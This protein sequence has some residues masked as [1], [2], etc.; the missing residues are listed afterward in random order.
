MALPTS[1]DTKVTK[2]DFFNH[3]IEI[4]KIFSGISG[5]AE[6][7]V[8]TVT[9][10][11]A[12]PANYPFPVCYWRGPIEPVNAL[13]GDVFDLVAATT[14]AFYE[15][16]FSTGTGGFTAQANASSIVRDTSRSADGALRWSATAAGNTIIQAPMK[17]GVAPSTS[18]LIT[19]K[20]S[21]NSG[22]ALL[23]SISV[24]EHSSTGAYIRTVHQSPAPSIAVGSGFTTLSFTHTTSA[25]GFNTT[26]GPIDR[27]QVRVEVHAQA[28]GGYS[29]LDSVRVN[30]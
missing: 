9:G 17:T 8:I 5:C 27:F 26:T 23:G 29:Y 28:A 2:Q 4:N 19:V 25:S 30:S 14:P 10:D 18:Y 3:A 22:T 16:L 12:R 20:I 21:H 11:E 1:K 13:D 6:N 7:P 15:E 24:N